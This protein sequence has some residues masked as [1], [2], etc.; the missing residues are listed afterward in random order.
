MIFKFQNTKTIFEHEYLCSLDKDELNHSL[1]PSLRN[2]KN[3]I[4]DKFR[5]GSFNPYITS[6]GLYNDSGELLVVGKL[7]KPIPKSKDM[8]MNILVKWDN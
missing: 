8:D 5:S 6:I 2:D 7:S 3:E 4:K 1:N